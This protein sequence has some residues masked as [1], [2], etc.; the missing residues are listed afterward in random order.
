MLTRRDVLRAGLAAAAGAACSRSKTPS[1]PRRSVHQ[2]IEF[3]E[4]FPGGADESAPL[5][6]AIHGRGDRPESWIPTWRAFPARVQVALPRAESAHG[7]GFSWFELR[8]GMTDE[9]LGAEVGA[10]EERLFRGVAELAAGRRPIVTGFSQ[11]GILTFAIAARRGSETARAFP[12]AGSC[13]G[14]LLPKEGERAAPLVAFHGTEDR[15]LDIKWGRAAVAAFAERG[16][17][18]TIREYPGVGH[19]VTDAMRADLWDAI[20][21]A[22]PATR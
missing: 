8:D 5:V 9:E 22:L 17:E 14:P 20:E 13:P 2:G 3:H 21:A 1:W 4:L 15:V 11:G 12:V 18:A 6:V 7:D 19:T 16:N 10:A